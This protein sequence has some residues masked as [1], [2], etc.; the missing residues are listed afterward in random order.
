MEDAFGGGDIDTEADAVYDQ[1][2]AEQGIAAAGDDLAVGTGAISGEAGPA[3]VAN[4]N[5]ADDLQ[6]RLDNLN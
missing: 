5:E 2:C 6:K 1:I 3:K 4:D